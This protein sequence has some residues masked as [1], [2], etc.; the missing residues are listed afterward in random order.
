MLSTTPPSTR[1]AAP[2]GGGSLGRTG[3]DHHVGNLLGH[4][5]KF[6]QSLQRDGSERLGEGGVIDT[7]KARAGEQSP[8]VYVPKL[9]EIASGE[10]AGRAPRRRR[11]ARRAAAARRPRGA[12]APHGPRPTRAPSPP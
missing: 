5:G 3:V 1:N 9:G 2:G 11:A 12:R 4:V 10:A 6:G 7:G 8:L